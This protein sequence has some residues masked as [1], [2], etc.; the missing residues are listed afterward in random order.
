[1][2]AWKNSA[3]FCARFGAEQEQRA[4]LTV[5]RGLEAVTDASAGLRGAYTSVGAE[6]GAEKV[7]LAGAGRVKEDWRLRALEVWRETKWWLGAL[8]VVRIKL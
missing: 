3:A 6:G 5:K 8:T 1:V 2:Y 7:F 4:S